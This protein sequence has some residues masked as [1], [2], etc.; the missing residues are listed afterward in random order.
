MSKEF[1][2]TF[3]NLPSWAKGVIS[4][5]GAAVTLF[6]L[7][8]GYKWFEKREAEKNTK[9]VSNDAKIELNNLLRSGVK[10]SYPES[11]YQSTVNLI[12]R[13]LDGCE[14]TGS[15]VQVVEQIIKVVK[16]K[17]DWAKLVSDFGSRDIADCGFGK[18]NYDLI[19]LLNDQLDTVIVAG[20]VNGKTYIGKD[21]IVPLKEHLAKIGVNI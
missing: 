14:L 5:A 9:A 1:S 13:L 21:T 10:L 19:T 3:N 15:E 4:V 20:T 11:T 17:A 18:T 16:N 2:K 6:V 7:Y 8:K 12:A